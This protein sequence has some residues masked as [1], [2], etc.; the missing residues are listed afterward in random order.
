VRRELRVPALKRTSL[1]LKTLFLNT[2][3]RVF[4]SKWVPVIAWMLLIFAGS[5]DALS[6]EHTSRFVAPFLRWL[7]PTISL[8]TI[9]AIHFALRKVGH[10]S[11]YA[12]LAVLLWRALRGTFSGISRGVLISTAFLVCAGFAASDEFHQSFVATRTASIHDVLIDCIGALVAVLLCVVFSLA[13]M[14]Q[15][16]SGR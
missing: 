5:T 16:V 12:I 6:A 4:V 13:T 14:R 9:I 10:F 3:V 2:N 8:E 15:P 11:E 1:K 7:D